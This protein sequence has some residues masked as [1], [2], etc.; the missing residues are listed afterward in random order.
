MNVKLYNQFL[1]VILILFGIVILGPTFFGF[2]GLLFPAFGY[3]PSLGSNDFSIKY[4]YD[5]FLI[6]GIL[7]SI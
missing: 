2:L 6:P 7:K 3:F 1:K 5:L 4:F